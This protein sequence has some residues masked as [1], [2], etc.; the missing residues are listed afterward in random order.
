MAAFLARENLALILSSIGAAVFAV[1][2][3]TWGLWVDSLVIL[4]DG[5]YSLVSLILSL[6]SVYAARLM[7]KPAC[8]DFP[9][10]RGALEPLV[11]AIKGLTIALVCVISLFSAVAALFSG[12]QVV[13]AGMALIFSA[14]SVIGCALVWGY[15]HWTTGRNQSGLLM[16]EKKQW[17][18]DMALSAAVLVGFGVAAM[19]ETSAWAHLARYADPMMM[20]LISGYFLVVPLKMTAAAVRELLLSAPSE[21]LQNCVSQAMRDVGL[22][23]DCAS[24][25][26]VGPSLMVEVALPANWSDDINRLRFRLRR[27]L[28]VLPLEPRI[29]VHAAD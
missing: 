23:P 24:T 5:A 1:L 28:S 4:F 29:F 19:L 15:L 14:V 25:I 12:G 10:G 16:A 20:V 9:L 22:H 17:L 8:D 21:E 26:K 13:D 11:I 18:M 3:I 6:L 27:K 7:R 2:G